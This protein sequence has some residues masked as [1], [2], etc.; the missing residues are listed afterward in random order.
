MENFNKALSRIR[1]ALPLFA[2]LLLVPGVSRATSGVMTINGTVHLT[3]DHD[4]TI[5]M[6][7]N[8][9]L[10][11]DGHGIFLWVG[12]PPQCNGV[13]C[14]IRMVGATNAVV[15]GCRVLFHHTGIYVRQSNSSVIRN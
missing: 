3:E 13:S 10:F 8:S 5:V 6:T 12:V 2:A 9:N 11:C 4:G 15:H 1:G 7:P 14:G